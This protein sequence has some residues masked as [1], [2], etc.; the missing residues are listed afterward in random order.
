MQ[1]YNN[2]QAVDRYNTVG[3]ENSSF[4]HRY[5]KN[6]QIEDRNDTKVEN[7]ERSYSGSGWHISSFFVIVVF[8][9]QFVLSHDVYYVI[10]ENGIRSDNTKIVNTYASLLVLMVAVFT[11]ISSEN[12]GRL[13]SAYRRYYQSCI[14]DFDGKRDLKTIRKNAKRMAI[15][16]SCLVLVITVFL[17]NLRSMYAE[18]VSIAEN[19]EQSAIYEEYNLA[20]PE[21]ENIELLG[22]IKVALREYMMFVFCAAALIEVFCG[23]YLSAVIHYHWLRFVNFIKYKKRTRRLYRNIIEGDNYLHNDLITHFGNHKVDI[24]ALSSVG[25][26]ISALTSIYRAAFRNS[27]DPESYLAPVDL[28]SEPAD[29]IS[30]DELS[31]SSTLPDDPTPPSYDQAISDLLNENN[32]AHDLI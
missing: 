8:V 13:T 17:A 5:V 4:K 25:L 18:V 14:L 15:I 16:F 26:N 29:D 30:G 10:V 7:L 31:N 20:T 2:I 21:Q 32:I 1:N 12:Y 28:L 3:N 23:I 9:L 22:A 19:A 24:A 6:K 27:D 11:F